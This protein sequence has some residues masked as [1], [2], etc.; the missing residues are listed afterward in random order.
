MNKYI[1]LSDYEKVI[2]L[3]QVKSERFPLGISIKLEK[4]W[5]IILCFE[6][7]LCAFVNPFMQ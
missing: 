3:K 1:I 4:C 5:V 6:A 2:K 7:G